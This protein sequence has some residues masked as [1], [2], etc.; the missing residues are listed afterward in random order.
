[1]GNK[2]S[3][4]KATGKSGS[5]SGFV[6]AAKAGDAA[7]VTKF[8]QSDNCDIDERDD[9]LSLNLFVLHFFIFFFHSDFTLTLYR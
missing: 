5:A 3:K 6:L 4:G 8:L 2:G 7:L 9:G 1:M